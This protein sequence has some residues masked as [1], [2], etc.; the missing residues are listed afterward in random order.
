MKYS[1][2]LKMKESSQDPRILRRTWEE[3]MTRDKLAEVLREKR[4]LKN[5]RLDLDFLTLAIKKEWELRREKLDLEILSV[6]RALESWSDLTLHDLKL[7]NSLSCSDLSKIRIYDVH[8]MRQVS[9]KHTMWGIFEYHYHPK[10]TFLYEIFKD[11]S[12]IDEKIKSELKEKAR[13]EVWEMVCDEVKNDTSIYS[14]TPS[15]LEHVFEYFSKKEVLDKL[16][17]AWKKWL[18]KYVDSLWDYAVWLSEVDKDYNLSDRLKTQKDIVNHD[19]DLI[20][21]P[22]KQLMKNDMEEEKRREME[23]IFDNIR[24]PVIQ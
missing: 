7:L 21:T 22:K 13:L 9:S 8:W 6:S 3:Q 18:E 2:F 4:L 15:V 23:I 12:L 20:E 11:S 10:Y 19:E 14:L 16:S 24:F 5:N 17:Q 1:E